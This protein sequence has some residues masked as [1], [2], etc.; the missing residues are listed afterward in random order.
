MV[1]FD[2]DHFKVINDTHGHLVGDTVL[3]ELAGL[4]QD[5]IRQSDF[6]ARWGGEEFV[7][8]VPGIDTEKALQFAEKMRLLIEK[9]Q[10]SRQQNITCSFGIS[11]FI[12]P[13]EENTFLQRV[14]KAL[15][16]AKQ[17]GRNKCILL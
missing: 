2:I 10:F 16:Q 11:S 12:H 8:L 7:V 6:H 3:K 9:F 15:Y 5:N 4:I 13:E 17:G 14:D 1:L